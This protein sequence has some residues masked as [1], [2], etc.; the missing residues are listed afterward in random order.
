[1][2]VRQTLGKQPHL[3]GA[4]HVGVAGS[5]DEGVLPRI[6]GGVDDN[7]VGFGEVTYAV[8]TKSQIDGQAPDLFEAPAQL[9]GGSQVSYEHSRAALNEVSRYSH[10]A[11]EPAQPHYHDAA[12]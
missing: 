2:P 9:V 5:G 10:T 7:E 4:W 11:A 1:M 3:S 6:D 12:G 8:L